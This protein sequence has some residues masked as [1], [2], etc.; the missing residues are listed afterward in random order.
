M[1]DINS[2]APRPDVFGD[3]EGIQ[4]GSDLPSQ[5]GSRTTLM[6]GIYTF[7]IPTNLAQ[8]WAKDGVKVKDSRQFLSNGQPNP[9]FDQDVVREQIKFSKESPLIVVG[10]E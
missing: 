4:A 10:G 6:P 8:L 9:T 3:F 2:S 1:T 5:G 7:R